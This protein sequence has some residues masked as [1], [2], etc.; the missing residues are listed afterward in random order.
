M[1]ISTKG[2][3]ALRLMVDIAQ[4]VDDGPVSLRDAARRQQLSD[5]YLEQIVTPLARA[6][7]VRSVRGAGGGYL[8]TR[9]HTLWATFSARWREIWPR[10]SAP[11]TA[12]TVNTAV[13]A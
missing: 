6:G 1:K 5:K 12:A 7:L 4:H 9:R 13:T 11:P 10:W 3:Y 8:L 2:R